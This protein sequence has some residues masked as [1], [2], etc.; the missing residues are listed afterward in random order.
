MGVYVHGHLDFAVW[1]CRRLKCRRNGQLCSP[2]TD[3]LPTVR[4]VYL[5]QERES[6]ILLN[7]ER[8]FIYNLT[9]KKKEKR[10]SFRAGARLHAGD[11]VSI[12]ISKTGRI[13]C[14]SCQ[15][16]EKKKHLPTTPPSS[17]S[18]LLR[19][20]ARV[21]P[22]HLSWIMV[23]FIGKKSFG[24]TYVSTRTMSMPGSQPN[25]TEKNIYH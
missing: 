12:S 4:P 10:E 11:W 8:L 6:I 1:L 17:Q 23:A 19:T 20:L 18:P 3:E 22:L 15:N 2:V 7:N 5:Y 21:R 13:F 16:F 24:H 9:E 25:P 14:S